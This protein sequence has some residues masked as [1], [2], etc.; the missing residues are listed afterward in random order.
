M[1]L[2]RLEIKNVRV[3]RDVSLEPGTG[4]N[5]IVGPNASGKTTLLEAIHLLG[6]GRSFRTKQ[7]AGLI[8][9]GASKWYIFGESREEKGV[10]RIGLE[11]DGQERT[12]HLNG[13]P[14]G[15]AAALAQALPLLAITPDTHYQFLRSGAHRRGVLDWL[16][17]HVEQDFHTHWLRYRRL[18]DQRNAALRNRL[19]PAAR[20]A[21]D[22]ELAAT[23]ERLTFWRK[24]LW[25][26]WHQESLRLAED[27][28]EIPGVQLHFQ[29]GWP[30][31]LP[32]LEQLQ[33]DRE[34]DS[35]RGYTRSGPQRADIAIVLGES[36][37]RSVAS[38]GQQKL[39]ITALRLAQVR[40]L[41]Q[42]PGKRCALLLDDI[43]AELDARHRARAVEALK[44]L[45]CQVFVTSLDEWDLTQTTQVFHVEHG[46]IQ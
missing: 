34:L 12:I 35:A 40:L 37:A 46:R 17:F 8:Q 29:P 13:I 44:T 38:H 3:L 18:L 32:L 33:R 43:G 6:T 42:Q 23:G 31:D 28:L 24:T 1:P 21:W 2:T 16:L 45:D 4:T 9:K 26:R 14:I 11:H 41:A 27:L 25:Q 20:Y 5:V 10:S 39:L 15:S 19:P 22:P 36:E 30:Q 7:L